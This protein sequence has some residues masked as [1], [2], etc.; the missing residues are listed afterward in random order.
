M[1]A[2]VTVVHRP[3]LTFWE[4]TYLPQIFCGLK[5]TTRHFFRN[6]FLHITHRLGLLKHLPASVTIQYTEQLR[7]LMSR[8]ISRHR[9]NYRDD[10]NTR[11]VG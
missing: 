4:K 6:L 9:L 2:K 5:I 1:P 3:E 10:G 11:C 8:F 7:P